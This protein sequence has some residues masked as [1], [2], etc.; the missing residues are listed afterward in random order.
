M[1]NSEKKTVQLWGREFE[2][3]CDGL[4]QTEVVDF[5]T[6][7]LT[8][9]DS[10]CKKMEQITFLEKLAQETIAEADNLAV[11]IQKKA[12][13][14]A[15][16][17]LVKAEEDAENIRKLAREEGRQLL[18]RGREHVE[19]QVRQ[20]AE[21]ICRKAFEQ[22]MEGIAEIWPEDIPAPASLP[23]PVEEKTT[24]VLNE[25][26]V[27][28][29]TAEGSAQPSYQGKVD[30]DIVPPVDLGQLLKLRKELSNIPQLKI[31]Q[32]TSSQKKGSRISTLV[33]EPIPLLDMIKGMPEVD[34]V[35]GDPGGTAMPDTPGTDAIERI[36]I[37]LATAE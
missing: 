4:S 11:S 3:V 28:A 23:V 16:S 22:V 18:V 15:A 7:L 20:H 13:E 32:I 31:V 6:A 26:S 19:A 8:E 14:K 1:L 37:K 5:V 24:P 33:T 36:M 27:P 21:Q 9:N 29:P 30:F 34:Q 17:I 10:L 35:S 25:S 12:E 2:V